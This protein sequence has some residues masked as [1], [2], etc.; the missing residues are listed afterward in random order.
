M[1]GFDRG[2]N[3]LQAAE[4]RAIL[5]LMSPADVDGKTVRQELERVLA[6]SGFVKNERSST[7]LRFVVERYLEGASAEIKETVIGVEVFG[8]KPDYNPKQDAIVR[9]EA[10]RFGQG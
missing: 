1:R 10:A 7:F 9:T 8:R 6:S 4:T 2:S 3:P 5:D